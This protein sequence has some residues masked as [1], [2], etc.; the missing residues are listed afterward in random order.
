MLPNLCQVASE[1]R[2]NNPNFYSFLF[3]LLSPHPCF[4]VL[5]FS[6]IIAAVCGSALPGFS[7]WQFSTV[8]FFFLAFCSALC[9]CLCFYLDMHP[10]V[11]QLIARI[12]IFPLP[13]SP[14]S[15]AVLCES[16]R[17]PVLCVTAVHPSC[18][19]PTSVS[20]NPFSFNF[21]SHFCWTFL[22]FLS[23]PF[24]ELLSDVHPREHMLL[25]WDVDGYYTPWKNKDQHFLSHQCIDW[26]AVDL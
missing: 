1:T 14:L 11:S 16:M 18:F 2:K 10:T 17:F 21:G 26:F 15:S 25:I 24:Q 7:R 12:T 9:Y 19:F 22:E 3:L 13:A 20:F 5:L 23:F 6:F 8:H 4:V